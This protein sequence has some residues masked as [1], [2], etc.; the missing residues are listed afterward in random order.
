MAAPALAT[1]EEMQEPLLMWEEELTWREEALATREEKARIFE[2]ALAQVSAA[3]DAEQ[4]Q[5]EATRQEYL[6]KI[7]SHV[8]HGNHVLNIT[9]M[10]GERKEELDR[11]ERDLELCTAALV[12]AQGRGLNPWDNRDELMELVKLRGLLW[13][14]EVDCVIEVGYLATLV[15]DV[16]KVLED[17]GRSPIPGI[18]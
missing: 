6:D 17:L 18:P 11:K 9:K 8:D 4:A 1:V 16:F 14:A 3:L 7:Q 5:A 2:K 10:I 15:R 13:E 12:K